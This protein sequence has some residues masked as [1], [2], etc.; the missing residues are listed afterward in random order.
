[1]SVRAPDEPGS[2]AVHE[3]PQLPLAASITIYVV[4]LLVLTALVVFVD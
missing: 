3:W 4:A 2:A 1:M